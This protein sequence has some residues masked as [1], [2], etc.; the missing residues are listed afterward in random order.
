MLTV[1]GLVAGNYALTIDN[2][3]VADFSADALGHGVNLARM[4]TPMLRQSQTLAWETEHRNNLERQLFTLQAGTDRDPLAA[5]EPE[6]Q[7][8]EKA[9]E[10]SISQQQK[11]AQ[12]VAHRFALK[13]VKS[14]PP[15][16]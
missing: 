16:T 8:L 9:I 10:A 2:Q 15:T 5:P 11:D 4:A 6:Q 1:T 7:A 12:P 14:T 3:P 13:P